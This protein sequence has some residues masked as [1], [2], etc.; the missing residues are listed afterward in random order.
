MLRIAH[1]QGIDITVLARQ[2]PDLPAERVQRI[3]DEVKAAN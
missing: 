1:Q 2:Y 3:V